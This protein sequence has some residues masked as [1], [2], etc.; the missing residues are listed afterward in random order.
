MKSSK[1]YSTPLMTKSTT[2]AA[3]WLSA[4][5]L[6][7]YP[8]ESVWGIGCDAFNQRAV[9][10]LLTIKQRPVDKGMIVVTDSVDRIVPLLEALSTEQRQTVVDSWDIAPNMVSQQA[11]TWLLPL[12]QSLSQSLPQSLSQSLS[13]SS[14]RPLC[15]ALAVPIP[16]WISGAHNSVA[17]RVISHPLIQQ[18]CAQVVSAANPYGFIVSTSCNLS[19]QPPALSLAQAQAYFMSS[20]FSTHVGYLEGETLG[21]QLPSQIGDA[22]TGRVIR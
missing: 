19:G 13:Q 10:Q 1:S 22:L 18:L 5:Q 12:P 15:N 17:V 7:V 8:T 11:H 21:Y 4:G 6:L 2:Q 16:A 3:Q 20:D 9:Q 14:S